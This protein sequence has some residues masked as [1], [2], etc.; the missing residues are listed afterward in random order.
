MQTAQT[1]TK[2]DSQH[3]KGIGDYSEN[4]T[5]KNRTPQRTNK[6]NKNAILSTKLAATNQKTNNSEQTR[7]K[8]QLI[9]TQTHKLRKIGSVVHKTQRN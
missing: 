4:K 1:R 6:S 3:I 7:L 9:R 2:L 8:Q 5:I